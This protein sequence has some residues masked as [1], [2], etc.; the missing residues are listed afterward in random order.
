M[1]SESKFE[2]A[3]AAI[4]GGEHVIAGDAPEAADFCHDEA[5]T[6]APQ[7]PAWVVSPGSAEQ[8]AELLALATKEGFPVTARGSGSGLAGAG[9]APEGGVIISM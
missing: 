1:S 6:A 2:S 3:L 5:L 9:V 7:T 4:V 8:V